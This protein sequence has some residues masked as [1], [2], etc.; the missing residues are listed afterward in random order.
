MS[1]TKPIDLIVAAYE[2]GQ[3]HFGENYVQ[4]L[5]E[6]ASNPIILEKCKDIQWHFI[7]HLQTNKINNILSAPNIHVIETVDSKKLATK[8]NKNWPKFGPPSSKLNIFVQVNTSGE[9][10]MCRYI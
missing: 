10:G 8:L 3:R 4:E 6:K 5:E 2:E 1:K 9:D 7:G